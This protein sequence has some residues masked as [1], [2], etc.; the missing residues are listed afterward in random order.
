MVSPFWCASTAPVRA[1]LF[2]HF[3]HQSLGKAHAG[4]D[5]ILLKHRFLERR[6]KH[7]R[8]HGRMQS[9]RSA[10]IAGS[11][12]ELPGKPANYSALPEAAGAESGAIAG[13]RGGLYPPPRF[14]S[15][16]T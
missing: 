2:G 4:T 11:G 12:Q 6:G 14:Y 7:F 5:S 3:A 9:C 8:A 16:L 10:E 1:A 13:K 15:N